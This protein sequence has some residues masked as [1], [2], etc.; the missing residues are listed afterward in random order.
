[1]LINSKEIEPITIRIKDKRCSHKR[2]AQR[3]ISAGSTADISSPIKLIISTSPAENLSSSLF[4]RVGMSPNRSKSWPETRVCWS[5]LGTS[6]NKLNSLGE[7]YH[8]LVKADLPFSLSSV[9]QKVEETI[10]IMELRKFICFSASS[11][12]WWLIW[13]EQFAFLSVN[14]LKFFDLIQKNLT[15]MILSTSF[16]AKLQPETQTSRFFSTT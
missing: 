6:N 1:M 14:I 7:I 15:S 4:P 16:L 10:P 5:S 3:V 13:R 2:V 11:S 9:D 12:R 8:N